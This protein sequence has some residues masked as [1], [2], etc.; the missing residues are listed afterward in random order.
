MKHFAY[1]FL[2]L[3]AFCIA[4]YAVLQ[5]HPWFAAVVLLMVALTNLND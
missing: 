2:L 5:G 4:G 3:G 1:V